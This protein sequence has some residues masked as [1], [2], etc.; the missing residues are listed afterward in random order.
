[1]DNM[2]ELLFKALLKN[3]LKKEYEW[4]ETEDG[5]ELVEAPGYLDLKI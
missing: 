1:M 3:E 2:K 5:L 4:T